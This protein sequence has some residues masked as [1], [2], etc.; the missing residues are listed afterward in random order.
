MIGVSDKLG[1]S[2]TGQT[3][4]ELRVPSLMMCDI[5]CYGLQDAARFLLNGSYNG[6]SKM[7]QAYSRVYSKVIPQHLL[8]VLAVEGKHRS[9]P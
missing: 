3:N 2:S 4:P 1:A 7:F 6:C 8:T 9:V 5:A